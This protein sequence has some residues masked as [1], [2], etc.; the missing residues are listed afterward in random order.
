M[1]ITARHLRVLE[2]LVPSG[3]R[4]FDRLRRSLDFADA[5]GGALLGTRML[6]TRGCLIIIEIQR[7]SG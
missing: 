2:R 4:R 5:F 6:L 1:T 7:Y 3:E